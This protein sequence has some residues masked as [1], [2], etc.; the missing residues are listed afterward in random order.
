MFGTPIT[1]EVDPTIAAEAFANGLLA[2][3]TANGG[4]NGGNLGMTTHVA[5][6]C[7]DGKIQIGSADDGNE[8]TFYA[9]GDDFS[10][11][12]VKTRIFMSIGQVHVETG[13]VAGAIITS[14]KGI[15]GATSAAFHWAPMPLG[16]EGYAGRQFFLYAFRD[17][18][19][20]SPDIG[21]V[22]VSAGAV[23]S[24]VRLLNGAGDTVV[25]SVSLAPFELGVLFT[26][27]D[28]EFQVVATQPVFVGL[29]A[30]GGGTPGD[31]RLVPPLST[32]IIGQN[33]RS[34]VSALYDNTEVWWYRHNGELGKVTASPGSPVNMYSGTINELGDVFYIESNSTPATAGTFTITVNGETT[35]TIAYNAGGN[36]IL[37]ALDG[38]TS[39]STADFKVEAILGDNLGNGGTQIM[40]YCM[41]LLSRV[42]GS[43]TIDTTLLTGNV[44]SVVVYQT[45]AE[46]NNADDTTNYDSSGCVRYVANAPISSLSG[47]DGSGKEA[48]YYVPVSSL[49][50]RIPL[51]WGT[52][53]VGNGSQSCICVQSPF[54]GSYKIFRQDG[55]LVYSND[56]DRDASIVVDSEFKQRFPCA[57]NLTGTG[58]GGDSIFTEA[59]T[60]GYIEADVPINVIMNTN[61]N[62]GNITNGIA[63]NADEVV[64][65]GVTPETCRAEIRCTSDGRKRKR[66]IE[67][68]G[69][70]NWE[71][72]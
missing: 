52:N 29:L 46:A 37:T 54:K 42:V 6:I 63:T 3:L 53:Q 8:V 9:S 45:G 51:Y 43:P 30:N 28:S 19:G 10:N 25:D 65:Y 39:Y 47:A 17:S 16:V 68:T 26:N 50:Q 22:F 1:P 67:N 69:A 33:R 4:V 21:K 58:G 55:S 36:E 35:G 41:G 11:G 27:S 40:I 70:E 72:V 38:L 61:G 14:T 62:Q 2:N 31:C 24:E 57:W 23:S 18:Q 34:F 15:C 59:F 60:G 13:C 12:I 49:T 48:T 56:F 5:F 20:T 44:H 32:E 7:E 64:L 66:V 71:L